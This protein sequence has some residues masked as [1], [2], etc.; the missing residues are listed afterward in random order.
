M[1]AGDLVGGR[2]RIDRRAGAGAMAAVFEAY[3]TLVERR[4]ALKTLHPQGAADE[5]GRSRLKYEAKALREIVHPAVVR[6]VDHGIDDDRRP[7]LVMEWVDGE[8]L[9]QRLG[10]RE[11]A[12]DD[13]LGVVEQLAAGLSAAHER[14]VVHRDLKPSNVMLRRGEISEAVL[15]DFGIARVRRTTGG[16]RLTG[17][18]LGTPRYM[19]P[20]QIRGAADV[21]AKVDVFALGCMLFECL[22]GRS[23]FDGPDAMTVLAQILFETP[24]APSAF[25]AGLPAAVDELVADMMAHDVGRRPSAAEVVGRARALRATAARMA[26]PPSDAGSPGDAA[27]DTTS[28]ASM[29]TLPMHSRPPSRRLPPTRRP[30]TPVL[31]LQVGPVIALASRPAQ[32]G[33]PTREHLL[34][35]LASGAPVVGVWGRAGAGKTR[36]V[37]EAVAILSAKAQSPWDVAVSADLSGARSA[38]DAARAIAASAGVPLVATLPA[39]ATVGR[40]LGAMG[41]VLLVL[42]AI[43]AIAEPLGATV[44]AWTRAAPGLRVLATSRSRWSSAG[45]VSIEVPDPTPA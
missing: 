3:D 23:S 22:T 5:R 27:A 10:R 16:L 28:P 29:G 12:A 35:L 40:A 32:E 33:D 25:R 17:D 13:A 42:D 18:R 14:G 41:R 9:A 36:L 26:A 43:D 44:R 2:Y 30:P 15:V 19:A 34:A 24:A 20:E 8:T 4:V 37:A 21:D 45:V 39:E 11:I 31:R 7:F 6:Y 38:D 1:R